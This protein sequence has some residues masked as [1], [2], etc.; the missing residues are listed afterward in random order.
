MPFGGW[1]LQTALIF[2]V[3]SFA[4]AAQEGPNPEMRTAAKC[5]KIAALS[6]ADQEA[7]SA[8]TI[9]KAAMQSCHGAIGVASDA[10]WLDAK[11]KGKPVTRQKAS[12]IMEE[13]LADS[14]QSF[15]I[16]MR[17]MARKTDSGFYARTAQKLASE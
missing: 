8:A 10:A 6:F 16:E 11:R 14:T 3:A 7:E 13:V 4:A 2:F 17:S 15:V 9:A 1:K 5:L 12:E